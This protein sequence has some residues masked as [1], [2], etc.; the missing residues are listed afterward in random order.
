HLCDLKELQIRDGLHIFGRAPEGAAATDLLV[1][2]VR[3]ARGDGKG[4]G[5]AI[6]QALAA[7][8]DLGADPQALEMSDPWTGRRPKIL[9]PARGWRSV[10]DT[11]ERLETLARDLVA[12]TRACPADW[13]ATRTV[14]TAVE[15]RLRPALAE[16]GPAELG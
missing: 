12:G 1:A 10:G 2:L 5:A 15:T 6:L 14:L 7:D 3:V 4:G 8:L 13:H 9:G 11:I 16:S